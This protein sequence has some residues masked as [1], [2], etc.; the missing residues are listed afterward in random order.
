MT[1]VIAISSQKGGVAKTTT[2]YALGASLAER[3][4]AVLLIDM[5]PQ[6]NLTLSFG[7]DP[8]SLHHT[9]GDALLEHDSLVAVSREGSMPGLDLVPANQG[10]VILDRVLYGRQS[11]EYRLKTQL[12]AMNSGY[13]DTILID[14]PPYFGTLTLNALTAAD[15][16]IVPVQCEYYAARAMRPI[17]KLVDLMRKKTNPDLSYRLLI[18]LYDRRN[19]ISRIIREQIQSTF[20]SALYETIIE[21]DTKLRESPTV[22][23]P[24][25]LYA[26]RTRGARQYRALAEELIYRGEA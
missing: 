1:K 10:L 19:K 7:V 11:Y 18:T 12:E 13:Y 2:C 20:H 8:E 16:L 25:N 17:L 6:A 15:R 23:L 5:D 14:C 3:G 21:I 9:V 26:P 22:G 4:K 24:I